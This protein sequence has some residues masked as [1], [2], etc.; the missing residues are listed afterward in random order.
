M[1][2]TKNNNLKQSIGFSK[3][4]LIVFAVLFAAVG[5]YFLLKSFA[6]EVV[7][8]KIEA[9]QMSLPAGAL[10]ATQSGASGGQV[11]KMNQ[12]GSLKSN[13][14]LT[15]TS[16]SFTLNASALKCRKAWPKV[17]VLIDGAEV[18][19]INIKSS[20]LKSFNTAKTLST[21]QHSIELVNAPVVSKNCFTTTIIDSLTFNGS[22]STTPPPPTQPPLTTPS[23]SIAPYSQS[24][25][26]SATFSVEVRANS[27]TT[28]VNAVQANINYPVDLLEVVGID[29]STSRFTSEAQATYSGGQIMLARGVIGGI[30]GDQL[31]AKVTFRA[32]AQNGTANLAIAPG[33][34]LV[35]ASTNQN[36]LGSA[37]TRGAVITIGSTSPTGAG[38]N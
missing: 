21:G 14:N 22:V 15:T 31:I 4:K 13:I 7:V 19:S 24:V 8:A 23:V 20:G 16:S 35:S 5:S 26:S 17:Q 2:A 3:N 10:P 38:I 6:E 29:S 37:S 33:T 9:E 36:I 28:T 1:P 11:V 32:K 30:S 18:A 27:G 25:G 34:S 12:S